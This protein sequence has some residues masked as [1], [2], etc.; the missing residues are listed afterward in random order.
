MNKFD[1]FVAGFNNLDETVNF[2]KRITGGDK[3]LYEIH[4][5]A[6]IRSSEKSLDSKPNLKITSY[7]QVDG[8]IF[9]GI[10]NCLRVLKSMEHPVQIASLEFESCLDTI[11]V[12]N[13]KKFILICTRSGD[14]FIR[15]LSEIVNATK[16][17]DTDSNIIVYNEEIIHPNHGN[18]D[19]N[20][21]F[22]CPLVFQ[23]KLEIT[24]N[25][26]QNSF[27][28]AFVDKTI[29]SPTFYVVTC[30]GLIKKIA[31]PTD[32]GK[33]ISETLIDLKRNLLICAYTSS[34]LC[35]EGQDLIM[36][37]LRTLNYNMDDC[38]GLKCLQA[39]GRNLL[40]MDYN[41]NIFKIQPAK[42]LIFGVNDELPHLVN[43][44]DALMVLADGEKKFVFGITT[45]KESKIQAMELLDSTSVAFDIALSDK[46]NLV[47]T[48]GFSLEIPLLTEI[49]KNGNLAE[50]RLQCIVQTD[51]E[52]RVKKLIEKGLID[53]AEIFAQT[54]NVDPQ[55][56]AKA[57][58]EHIVAQ[59]EAT[60]EQIEEFL[61]ILENVDD[62]LFKMSCYNSVTCKTSSDTRKILCQGALMDIEVRDSSENNDN[63]LLSAKRRFNKNLHKFDTFMQVYKEYD[64]RKWNYFIDCE[65]IDEVK[66]FLKQG[67][68][69]EASLI[70]SHLEH[71]EIA[72]LPD[73]TVEEV[74]TIINEAFKRTAPF[75]KTFI[76]LTLKFKPDALAILVDWVHGKVYRM[77]KEVGANF[78]DCAIIFLEDITALMSSYMPARSHLSEECRDILTNLL[79]A[80]RNVQLL[81]NNFS[82]SLPLSE[83]ISD[84]QDI[85]QTLLNYDLEAQNFE[86]LMREFLFPFMLKCGVDTDDLLIQQMKGIFL[87]NEDYW[88]NIVHVLLKFICKAD[89]K[90]EAIKNILDISAKPWSNK[91]KDVAR[92]AFENT[93]NSPIAEEIAELL[94]DEPM[95]IVLQ[96]YNINKTK[97]ATDKQHFFNRILYMNRDNCQTAIEDIHQLCR[98]DEDRLEIDLILIKAFIK[99]DKV[100]EAMEFFQKRPLKDLLT[101]GSQLMEYIYNMGQMKNLS[102]KYRNLYQSVLKPLWGII[103]T[104]GAEEGQ[105]YKDVVFYYELANAIYGIK[106]EFEVQ[107]DTLTLR[108]P[109]KKEEA[110]QE[111]LLKINETIINNDHPSFDATVHKCKK[112][113]SYF[114]LSLE[115]IFLRFMKYGDN[116][117]TFLNIGKYLLDT[118]T[119]SE[120]LTL[121]AVYFFRYTKD[122]L[123]NVGDETFLDVV[124]STNRSNSD[125]TN[126]LEA[127]KLA[128]KLCV[129]ALMFAQEDQMPI[130]E[131]LGWID[132]CYYLSIMHKKLEFQGDIHQNYTPMGSPYYSGMAVDTIKSIFNVYCAFVETLKTPGSQ[133]LIY[134]SCNRD[135]SQID[136]QTEFYQFISQLRVLLKQDLHLTALNM[137]TVL[138][139]SSLIYPA[140]RE[141][142]KPLKD[143]FLHKIIPETIN[144]VMSQKCI[145]K[146]MFL[147]LTLYFDEKTY[148]QHLTEYLKLYKKQPK[149]L[150]VITQVGLNLLAHHRVKRGRDELLNILNMC[151]WWFRIDDPKLKYEWYFSCSP[152]RRLEVLLI[153]NKLTLE[154]LPEYCQDFTLNLQQCYLKY[155]EITLLNWQPDVEY[156]TEVSGRK[157]IKIKNSES[158]LLGKCSDILKYITDKKEVFDLTER[159]WPMINFYYYEVYLALLIVHMKVATS[160]STIPTIYKPLLQFLKNYKRVGTPTRSEME[161]WHGTFVSKARIEPLSEFRLPLT[162]T[163]LSAGIWNI[164]KQE[165]NL[166]TYKQWFKVTSILKEFIN[167]QDICTYAIS[168]PISNKLID[169]I[170]NSNGWEL[171]LKYDYLWP[172]VDECAMNISD[173]E[174]ATAAVYAL[175]GGMPDGADKVV[176]A[177]LSYKYAKLY[178]EA[179]PDNA[180][181]EKVYAKVKQRYLN[182]SAIHILHKY[183]LVK[184]NYLEQVAQPTDLIWELYNDSR[185]ELFFDNLIADCPDINKAVEELCSLFGLNIK[186]EL[187][188]VLLKLLAVPS[189]LELDCRRLFPGSETLHLKRVCY[190][191]KT[192]HLK[193]WQ[194]WL[195]ELGIRNPSEKDMSVKANAWRCVYYISDID[196]IEEIFKL[197]HDNVV[198]YLNKMSVIAKM[199][200]LGLKFE[201]VAELDEGNK[202]RLLKNLAKVNTIAAIK[203]IASLCKIYGFNDL[204]YWEYIVNSA[205]QFRMIKEL[206]DYLEFLKSRCVSD[207]IKQAWQVILFDLISNLSNDP[208]QKVSNIRE[209]D[210]FLLLKTCPVI[211]ELDV[212]PYIQECLLKGREDVA[213][214]LR[215]YRKL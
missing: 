158:E 142:V 183:Q 104:C 31:L 8:H 164:I 211:Y 107:V 49:Y 27:I 37:N 177:Q 9:F 68:A 200:D 130:L 39:V 171:N 105:T 88:L 117:E 38:L 100:D 79:I 191:C 1:V 48:H 210:V 15:N 125:D 82:I 13:C 5:L 114:G 207:C 173:L 69:E 30:N 189:P 154:S 42:F 182:Y 165:V 6:V 205:V 138:L 198:V 153:E 57:K 61:R 3:S 101:L 62:Q 18:G 190:L 144:A 135:V 91:V 72:N 124:A 140:L 174:R 214:V 83:Y 71:N 80:L 180:E 156:T 29:K 67:R 128:R 65:L 169:S 23:E 155:L 108:W 147:N 64:Q 52:L 96:K 133:Y 59:C 167:Q 78:P 149:K 181:V 202:K 53:R 116:F 203:C 56:I 137:V 20:V 196:T 206:Q 215:Q 12:S 129:K 47:N 145:D 178:R 123:E 84:P 28:G 85:V 151:K 102:D 92:M 115:N 16:E 17:N 179:N 159:I 75:L 41:G 103:S 99:Y 10:N 199:C 58:A 26:S 109:S 33:F 122:N 4:T 136:F 176:M 112:L 40:G 157:S 141:H 119:S 70:Y 195:Y 187:C 93:T 160:G 166:D 81:L 73:T 106:S 186:R 172:K 150:N 43:V 14:M 111:I 131:V 201:G 175:M 60:T 34:Y 19:G 11:V 146:A 184:E 74:L 212:E 121:C 63:V 120:T 87:Y 97:F 45:E 46:T 126:D 77:E 208:A 194:K 152:A 54:F 55:F 213:K 86:L 197:D 193:H 113:A 185:I 51:P 170:S 76:P 50:V 36:L 24:P 204:K 66:M 90:L 161:Q 209:C 98:D 188:N 22:D 118:S 32:D 44:F 21:S 132:S 7:Y 35:L 163:F 162:S 134:F 127:I 89:K 143:E 25:D 139:R 148:D 94:N 192:Q 168:S 95:L 110:L 2:G